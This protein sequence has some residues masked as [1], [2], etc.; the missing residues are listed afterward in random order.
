MYM[1]YMHHA[2]AAQLLAIECSYINLNKISLKPNIYPVIS[3]TY[4]QGDHFVS[5]R[6]P[7]QRTS[8]VA[9]SACH[10]LRTGS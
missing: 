3:S 5:S 10:M 9:P 7:F 8:H 6:P 1:C 2:Y 4:R